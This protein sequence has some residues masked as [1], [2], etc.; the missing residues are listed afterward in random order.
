MTIK[1]L[2]KDG[3]LIIKHI[4]NPISEK[5]FADFIGEDWTGKTFEGSI[6]C[7]G[8]GLTSLKGCPKVVTG[9]FNCSNNQLT[10]LDYAPEE[11][12]GYFDCRQNFIES[13]TTEN[14]PKINGIVYSDFEEF[15]GI[16][17]EKLLKDCDDEDDMLLQIIISIIGKKS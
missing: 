13:L 12:K 11:V 8:I 16:S 3:N 9:Y 17:G 10:S 15:N 14:F 4:N 1:I 6:D 2:Y 5:T 7:S